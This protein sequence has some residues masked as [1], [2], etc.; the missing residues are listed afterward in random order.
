[1]VIY[2]KNDQAQT[3]ELSRFSK[4]LAGNSS[5]NSVFTGDKFKLNQSVILP[6]AGVMLLELNHQ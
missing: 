2:N 5:A 1:M 4:V 6:H 3:L